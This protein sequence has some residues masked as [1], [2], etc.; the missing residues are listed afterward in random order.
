MNKLYDTGAVVPGTTGGSALGV[1][2]AAFAL[3]LTALPLLGCVPRVQSR[4]SAAQPLTLDARWSA[5]PDR[6]RQGFSQLP[7]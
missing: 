6:A 3:A 7:R 5:D 2:Q 1:F 4:D